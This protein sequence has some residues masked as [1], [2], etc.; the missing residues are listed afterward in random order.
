M[1][2]VIYISI[3]KAQPMKNMETSFGLVKLEEKN[4]KWATEPVNIKFLDCEKCR[5]VFDDAYITDSNKED[6]HL[7]ISNFY[8]LTKSVLL[9]VSKYAFQYYQDITSQLNPESSWYKDSYVYIANEN[10]V[11]NYVQFCEI[12][13]ITRNKED[14]TVYICLGASCD[15]EPEHG[16]QLVFKKGEFVNRLSQIDFILTNSDP[17]VVYED[18]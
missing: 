6:Y 11:W 1:L 17:A 12:L 8:N 4:E 5:F 14:N 15:W 7:A 10:D 2:S 18:A 13:T 3:N 9:A 16:L